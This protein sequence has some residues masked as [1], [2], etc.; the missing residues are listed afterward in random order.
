MDIINYNTTLQSFKL[1][2][3]IQYEFYIIGYP[4]SESHI[5]IQKL[6]SY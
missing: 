6:I 1:T 3:S 2:N 5:M 4:I